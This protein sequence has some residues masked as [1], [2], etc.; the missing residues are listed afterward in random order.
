MEIFSI[1]F[2]DLN[3]SEEDTRN[4]DNKESLLTDVKLADS[5]KSQTAC[6]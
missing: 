1:S 6:P 3:E 2:T 4:C 5:V